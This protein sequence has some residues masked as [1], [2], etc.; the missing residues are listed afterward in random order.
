ML[1][2]YQAVVN[3]DKSI[4]NDVRPKALLSISAI[5]EPEEPMGDDV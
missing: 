5:G 2:F 1:D 3:S 4:A